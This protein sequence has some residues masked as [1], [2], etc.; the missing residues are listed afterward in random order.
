M[1]LVCD[2]SGSTLTITSPYYDYTTSNNIMISLGL[3]NPT[4]ASTTFNLLLY[5]YYFSASIYSLTISTSATYSTDTTYTSGSYTLIGK[6]TVIMYPFE[7]RISTVA[8]APLRARF[9]LPSSS[10]SNAWGTFTLT[11]SQIGYST[12]H[13]C[14]ILAYPCYAAMMQQTQRGSYKVS[15]TS[16]GNTLTV[17]P[18]VTLTVSAGNYY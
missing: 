8:N 1:E 18:A 15:C 13:L 9:R 17:T 12:K 10:V 4:S 16:S 11:Y 6:S 2:V 3:T 14:Y 7:S 5:S